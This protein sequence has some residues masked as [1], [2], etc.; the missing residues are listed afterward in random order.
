MEKCALGSAAT[1][2]DRGLNRV[3]VDGA[4]DFYVSQ[5]DST[6]TSE[7][8]NAERNQ[9]YEN[10]AAA[11]ETTE[12]AVRNHS[13]PVGSNNLARIEADSLITGTY[14]ITCLPTT[15]DKTA[16]ALGPSGQGGSAIPALDAREEGVLSYGRTPLAADT[17][18]S[19]PLVSGLGGLWPNPVRGDTRIRFAIGRDEKDEVR[20]SIFDVGGRRVVEL[21]NAPLEPG[22]HEVS[23][24]GHDSAG[25]RVAA[26]VYFVRFEA[27]SV[28]ETRKIVH[29]R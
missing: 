9:W 8:L 14:A 17:N 16:P 3:V 29:L 2:P 28:R 23:W 5:Y 22:W 15:P 21:V 19:V 20:L 1:L 26:G 24:M 6:Y 12:Q 11:A 7:V 13:E 27:G 4:L 25:H 18:D 10:A